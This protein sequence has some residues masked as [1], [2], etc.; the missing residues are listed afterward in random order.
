M[1]AHHH[2]HPPPPPQCCGCSS[3]YGCSSNCDCNTTHFNQPHHCYPPSPSSIDSHPLLQV[4]ASHVLQSTT[5]SAQ[6]QQLYSHYPK[7]RTQNRKIHDQSRHSKQRLSQQEPEPEET[8]L[9]ISSLLSRIEALET[10]LH[11]FSSDRSHYSLRD[12][13]ARVIQLQFRAFLVRRSRALRELKDLALVKSAFTSLKSSISD[14]THFDIHS[15]SSK[16]MDLLVKLESI[17]GDD[18]MVRDGKRSISRDL[19]QFMD[20][21]DGVALKRRELSIK[22]RKN[23]RF[24]RNSDPPKVNVGKNGLDRDQREVIRK[25]R[26]RVEKIRGYTM[27]PQDD[28]EY[29]EFEGFQ[30]VSDEDNEAENPIVV[31]SGKKGPI[32]NGVLANRSGDQP[33]VKK[34]VSFAENDNLFKVFSNS[35]EASSNEEDSTS[36]NSSDGHGDDG[37]NNGADVEELKGFSL[38]TEDDEEEEG[39]VVSVGS[40]QTSNEERNPKTESVTK[41]E[42]NYKIN[43]HNEEFVF[44]APL[45]VQMDDKADLMK[46][47]NEVKILRT[48]ELNVF[49]SFIATSIMIGPILQ[50]KEVSIRQMGDLCLIAEISKALLVSAS[51][52]EPA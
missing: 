32:R 49:V 27:V 8:H 31:I 20:F 34:S 35:N 15:V 16:A 10:S 5:A 39:D 25:L 52:G 42:V 40:S 4:I 29:V 36:T 1:A 46:R 37:E 2:H 47:R 7:S 17:Q 21:I 44:S 18:S 13:A 28:D 12:V 9:L 50:R 26:E 33:R 45:P 6:Q 48:Q 38:G 24:S 19:V 22:A 30:H 3:G 41:G 51:S 14:E 11:R 43:G 23:A